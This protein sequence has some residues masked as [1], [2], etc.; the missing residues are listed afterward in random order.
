MVIEQRNKRV[1]LREEIRGGNK[2]GEK[3]QKMDV[4]W[5]TK[6]KWNSIGTE[7]GE[8]GWGGRGRRERRDGRKR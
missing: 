5:C 6:R 3:K 4:E 1:A 8:N 2:S 7:E